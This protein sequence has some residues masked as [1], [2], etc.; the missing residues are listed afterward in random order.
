MRFTTPRF[1]GRGSPLTMPSSRLH[2][3][4]KL[5]PASRLRTRAA[6]WSGATSCV[7]AIRT[8]R[9]RRGKG[10]CPPKCDAQRRDPRCPVYVD[11]VE[12]PRLQATAICVGVGCQRGK[13]WCSASR[14]ED[15]RRK[16]DELRQFPE[17]LGGGGQQEL[18]LG[19]IWTTEAQSTEPE[20]ALQMSEEHLDL[21]S[22]AT[23]D[24]VGLGLCDR[25]GLVTRGFMNRA[26]DFARRNVRAAFWLKRAGLAVM[27]ARKVDHRAV[28]RQ[29][30]AWLGESAVMEWM[31]PPDGIAMCQ[32]GDVCRTP[33]NGEGIHERS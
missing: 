27:L 2:W 13:A 5:S 10:R 14:G 29:P 11:F 7:D 30:V 28:F 3:L 32:G 26:C 6:G 17:V 22:F 20:D 18:V 19:S 21:L 16:G 12:K 23:R 15:W 33:R 25:T 31:P 9:R 4:L 1:S 8:Y 24:G